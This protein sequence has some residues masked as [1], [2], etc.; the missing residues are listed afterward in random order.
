MDK[1][2]IE[3]LYEEQIQFFDESYNNNAKFRN[4]HT[5][6]AP[7]IEELDMGAPD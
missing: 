4:D 5:A 3:K 2:Q 7:G 6:I 1:N